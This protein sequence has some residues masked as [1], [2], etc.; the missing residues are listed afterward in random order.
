M[1]DIALNLI[2]LRSTDLRRAEEFY[3]LIGVT[4]NRERH[5][6]GPEHLSSQLG[7]LV[8]ELYPLEGA[9]STSSVRLGFR[10]GSVG[11]TVM[12]LSESGVR[13]V[14]P[15]TNGLWGLR[16]V[17]VDPDGHRVELAESDL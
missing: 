13:V 12:K 16:A 8:L 4:F 6:S 10:V 7:P 9:A 15:P 1:A 2:V 3:N 14:T 17:V 5:G 11:E